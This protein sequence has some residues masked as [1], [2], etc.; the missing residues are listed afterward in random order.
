MNRAHSSARQ[1]ATDLIA[2]GSIA[3]PNG[4]LYG[5]VANG[6]CDLGST[7]PRGMRRR[8]LVHVTALSVSWT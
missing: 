7:S 3:G 5:R 1:F 8:H 2:L 6:T 4:W